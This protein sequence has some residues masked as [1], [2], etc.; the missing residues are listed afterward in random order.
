MTTTS[1]NIANASTPGYSR[2]RV[3]LTERP[4]RAA[5]RLSF[6]ARASTIA[7]DAPARRRHLADQ[8]RTAAGGFHRAEAFVA[9]AESLDDLLAG[10]ETGLTATMQAFANSLQDVAN[11]PSSTAA[12]QAL[13]SEARNLVARFDAMDQRIDEIGE[14]GPRAHD[15]RPPRE[16]RRSARSSPR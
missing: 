2:Q 7:H 8:L 4:I 1:N 13:L 3:E 12:R 5:G 9:L 14:R 16:S 10:T 15:G 11:D 6:S